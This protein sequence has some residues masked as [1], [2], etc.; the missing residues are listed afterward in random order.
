M[1]RIGVISDT[2]GNLTFASKALN[3]WGKVDCILHAG[4]GYRDALALA[5]M[6]GCPVY[7]VCGNTDG[8]FSPTE[9]LVDLQDLT[10]EDLKVY[11][12]LLTHGHEFS[13]ATREV[14]L[15]D[16]A[17]RR[18]AQI[19][20]YGHTHQPYSSYHSGI[21]V[22]NPGSPFRPRMSERSCGLI[23]IDDRKI[24]AKHLNIP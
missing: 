14:R 18:G 20:V 8:V 1:L 17:K 9:E 10:E 11:K 19:A 21:L 16:L 2:H 3:L 13:P 22:F 6:A 5:K 15:A 24:S 4:D 12:I 23:E 7:A